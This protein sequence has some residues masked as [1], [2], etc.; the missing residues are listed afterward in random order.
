[1]SLLSRIDNAQQNQPK[2][3]QGGSSFRRPA[4][5]SLPPGSSPFGRRSTSSPFGRRSQSDKQLVNVLTPVGGT[6][7]RFSMQ[8]MGDPFYRLL[9]HQL[10]IDADLSDPAE[11][12][13]VLQKG[14]E[15]VDA[16]TAKLDSAWEGYNLNGAAL[17]F[18]ERQDTLNALLKPTPMPPPM[19]QPDAKKKSDSDD[20]D[21][22]D[23]DDDSDKPDWL[24]QSDYKVERLRSIDLMLTLNVLARSRSQV[25]VARAPVVYGLEYLTRSIITDNPRLVALARATGSLPDNT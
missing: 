9:G 23:D 3:P 5:S 14:G 16:L 2:P 20:D 1:M 4:S 19:Q 12:A 25:L 7:V 21:Y 15:H 24:E 17:V 22:I 11:L 13:A 18:D 8:G 10:A 6:L